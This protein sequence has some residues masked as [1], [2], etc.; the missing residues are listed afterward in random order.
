[1]DLIQQPVTITGYKKGELSM[2]KHLFTAACLCALLGVAG[3]S[4]KEDLNS[5][6]PTQQGVQINA[7]IVGY[8][9][10]ANARVTVDNYG[11]AAW[12]EGDTLRL[13]A[14]EALKIWNQ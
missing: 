1:M 9:D 11:K 3:C 10:K 8:E 7:E 14:G 5:L 6:A 13:S 4:E 2:K 12:S